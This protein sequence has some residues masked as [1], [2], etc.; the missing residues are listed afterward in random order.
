MQTIENSQFKVEINE[1]G[2]ELTH[3]VNKSENFDYIWNNNIWPKHAPILFPAIGRSVGDTYEYN[4]KTYEMP[5]HG[6]VSDQDFT[7]EAKSD[8]NLVLALTANDE[9]KKFYPFNFKLII[10]FNLSSNGLKLIF[11]VDNLDNQKFSFSLGSHPAFNVPINGEGAFTDYQLE[12]SPNELNL[13]Q[14]EIIKVPAPYRT[15]KVIP[16]AGANKGTI[17]LNY[18]MFA[19]GL[20]IVE[21]DGIL[22][23]KLSSEKTN[24]SIEILLADFRYV[25]LWTKEGADAQFLC[26]EPFLGL[27]DVNGR[28]SELLTKEANIL[29]DPHQSKSF[30]YQMILK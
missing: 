15:G 4:G 17:N 27:P 10:A 23:V 3:L 13:N 18:E 12:F 19:A 20:V 25:C 11:T 28:Q 9:T 30:Q 2:A 21:N 14:F 1:H 6:F 16:I 29:L 5:Q 26:I 22:S 8:T 7:V 24:H